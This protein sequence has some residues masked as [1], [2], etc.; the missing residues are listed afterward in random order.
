MDYTKWNYDNKSLMNYKTKMG[1]YNLFKAG[2]TEEITEYLNWLKSSHPNFMF[3]NKDFIFPRLAEFHLFEIADSFF[4]IKPYQFDEKM[5]KKITFNLSLSFDDDVF[6]YWLSKLPALDKF[7][8]NSVHKDFWPNFLCFHFI[9]NEDVSNNI[10]NLFKI[11]GNVIFYEKNELEYGFF[12]RAR[13][14]FFA[15]GMVKL[16]KNN[17]EIL[18]HTIGLL[19]AEHQPEFKNVFMIEFEK[20]PSAI[21]GFETFEFNKKLENDLPYKYD[22]HKS[23]I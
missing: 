10:N 12:S 3:N 7:K 20:Y 8:Q 22:N 17:K 6:N 14:E 5:A 11:F 13:E 2:D 15:K 1:I 16:N 19:C 4:A 23:K 21:R 18:F 9:R